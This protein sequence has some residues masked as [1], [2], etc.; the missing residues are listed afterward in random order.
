MVAGFAT[1]ALNSIPG[2]EITDFGTLKKGSK[3]PVKIGFLINTLF[4]VNEHHERA[5]GRFFGYF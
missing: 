2:P 4:G 1:H 3:K 5:N